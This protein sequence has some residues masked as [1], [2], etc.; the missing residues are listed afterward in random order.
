[1]PAVY[2]VTGKS[3]EKLHNKL[4]P[5]V[6]LDVFIIHDTLLGPSRMAVDVVKSKCGFQHGSL[7]REAATVGVESA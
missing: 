6:K 2:H 4:Y 3:G 7:H 1:M 5:C